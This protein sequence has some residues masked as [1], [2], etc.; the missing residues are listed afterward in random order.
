MIIIIINEFYVCNCINLLN[1]VIISL[2]QYPIIN[3][4]FHSASFE[5]PIFGTCK[6]GWNYDFQ[7]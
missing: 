1:N 2:K 7:P 4:T 5:N 6:A 3:Y